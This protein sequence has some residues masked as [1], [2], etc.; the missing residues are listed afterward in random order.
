MITMTHC[1]AL[2]LV[3]FGIGAFGVLARRNAIIVLMGIELIINFVAFARFMPQP[4]LIGQIFSVFVITVAAGEVAIGLAILIAI[5]R[6][7]DSMNVDDF[8]ILRG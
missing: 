3:L 5:Y 8:N 2:S 4:S 1:L 6:T 7:R